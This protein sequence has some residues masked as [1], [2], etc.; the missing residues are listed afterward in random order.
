MILPVDKESKLY[1]FPNLAG[2]LTSFPF[3]DNEAVVFSNL[4]PTREGY[5]QG[6]YG[7]LKAFTEAI[8]TGGDYVIDVFCGGVYDGAW[9]LLAVT[10]E[11]AIFAAISTDQNPEIPLT[12]VDV[13]PAF[14]TGTDYWSFTEAVD[15]SNRQIILGCNPDEGLLMFDNGAT[16]AVFT[17]VN[18]APS[19]PEC[20]AQYQGYTLL[21]KGNSVFVS[22]HLDPLAWP[23]AQEIALSGSMGTVSSIAPLPGK[24]LV[25]CRRGLIELRGD[26]FRNFK[27]PIGINT[28]VGSAFPKTVSVYEND[29][30]FLHHT[31]PYI[32]NTGKMEVQYIGEP[33][34]EY[35]TSSVRDFDLTDVARYKWRGHLTRDYYFLTGC[36]KQTPTNRFVLAFNRR[37]NAWIEIVTPSAMTPTCFT[38]SE[39]LQI[40]SGY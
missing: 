15:S 14:L 16:S 5:A 12:P 23:G 20:V 13:S 33:I 24:C 30:A 10:N 32:Y 17:E 28:T 2:G 22:D 21:G 6:I 34:R 36:E 19:G 8:A 38:S 18:L 1:S 9:I 37:L 39:T 4:E 29:V 27:T 7:S 35:F 11:P 25:V 3:Q 31:G 26:N 40:S